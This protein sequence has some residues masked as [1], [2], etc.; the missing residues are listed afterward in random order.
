MKSTVGMLTSQFNFDEVQFCD[1]YLDLPYPEC[2]A[3]Y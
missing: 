1:E 2:Y 3:L